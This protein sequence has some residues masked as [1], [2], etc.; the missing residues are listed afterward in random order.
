MRDEVDELLHQD[1][2]EGLDEDDDINAAVARIE[3]HEEALVDAGPDEPPFE[4]F[5]V[6]GAI[7]DGNGVVPLDELLRVQFGRGDPQPHAMVLDEPGLPHRRRGEFVCRSCY[8][9]KNKRLLADGTK[10]LCRDCAEAA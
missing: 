7:D 5:Q 2:G 3:D 6:R 9:V 4:A 8:L 1:E 10:L